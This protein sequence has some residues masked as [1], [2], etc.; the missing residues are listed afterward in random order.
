MDTEPIVKTRPQEVVVLAALAAIGLHLVLAALFFRDAALVE[1]VIAAALAVGVAVAA[2][3]HYRS[4]APPQRGL[5]AILFGVPALLFGVGVHAVRVYAL[6]FDGSTYTGIAMLVAGAVLTVFGLTILVRQIRPWWRRLLMIPLGAIVLFYTVFPVTLG[7]ATTHTPRLPVC[8]DDTPATRGF[9]YEDVTF[10]TADGLK[11]TA[12][13]IPSRNRAAVITVHGAFRGRDRTLDQAAVLAKHGYGVLL[14]DLEGFG[15]SEGRVNS[16]GWVGAR[17]VHAAV[18]YLQSRPD[19]DPHRIGGLGLSMGGEVLLQ[20][21][22]ESD[23]LKAVVSEGG[24]ARTPDDLDEMPGLGI[25][26]ILPMQWVLATTLRVMSGEPPPPPLK[27]MVRRIG[28]RAVLLIS[29]NE[30]EERTLNRMYQEVG[31]ASFDLWE[32]PEPKH[33]G[34]LKLHPEE[35]E[36]RIIGFFD[37]SLLAD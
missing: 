26:A 17:D 3:F 9:A 29:A 32:I 36:Q 34:A 33:M 10:M 28:P 16:Y 22:G 15:D 8:C 5:L 2:G 7:I 1:R 24:S 23:A 13:Y 35:Y 25:K 31:G 21:A 11:L 4:L 19:I 6:G 20:A 27:E 18:A 37:A 30:H 14:I 12:W